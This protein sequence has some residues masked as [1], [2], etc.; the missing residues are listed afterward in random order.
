[1]YFARPVKKF[2]VY[3]RI[4][5]TTLKGIIPL[6]AVFAISILAFTHSWFLLNRSVIDHL[7]DDLPNCEE[8]Y[9]SGY[10][11]TCLSDFQ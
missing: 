10:D 7:D 5:E 1:L 6:L 2:G 3:I 4:L 9:D 8:E 11:T